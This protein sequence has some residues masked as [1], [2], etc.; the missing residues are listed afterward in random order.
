MLLKG[1]YPPY[2]TDLEGK[3]PKDTQNAPNH[4]KALIW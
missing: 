4:A 2:K 1:L 3:M